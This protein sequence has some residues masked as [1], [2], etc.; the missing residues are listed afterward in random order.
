MKLTY[1]QLRHLA[2]L[3]PSSNDRIV[4]KNKKGQTLKTTI[5]KW[6]QSPNETRFTSLATPPRQLLH[7]TGNRSVNSQHPIFWQRRPQ[8]ERP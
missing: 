8:V 4:L 5:H 7:H 2:Q 3:G 6:D 1:E